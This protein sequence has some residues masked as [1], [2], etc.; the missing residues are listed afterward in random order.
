MLGPAFEVQV[1]LKDIERS[2]YSNRPAMPKVVPT[3]MVTT[4]TQARISRGENCGRWPEPVV[5]AVSE[6]PTPRWTA[7]SSSFH[8]KDN[9]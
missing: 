3:F 8:R 9:K 2:M 4:I 5:I 1:W 6:R 7:S